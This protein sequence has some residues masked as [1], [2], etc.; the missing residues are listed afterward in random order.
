M[1]E[2]THGQERVSGPGS[3]LM[4][5]LVATVAIILTFLLGFQLGRGDERTIV[6]TQTVEAVPPGSAT[7]SPSAP[8]TSR[9]QVAVV[10]HDLQQA[11]YN[12]SRGAVWVVC[13]EGPA[14]ACQPVSYVVIPNGNAFQ[15]ADEHW[16]LVTVAN[17][18]RGT[19][20]YLIAGSPSHTWITDLAAPF[21]YQQ[22]QGVTLNGSVDYFDLGPLAAGRYV[23]VSQA[24]NAFTDGDPVTFA[25]GL[26]IE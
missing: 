9:I 11:Y 19:R 1:I 8:P 18:E 22:L 4:I 17:I 12:N 21:G 13:E 26:D 10:D 20:T 16:Q 24:I 15:P 2:P 5:G 14:L 25:I 3:S 6:V 23:V 7:P